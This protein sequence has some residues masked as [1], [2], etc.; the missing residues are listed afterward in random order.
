VRGGTARGRTE[1]LRA[2]P[3]RFR[4]AH[5]AGVSLRIASSPDLAALST[6]PFTYAEVGATR[7]PATMPAGYRHRERSAVVGSG[8]TAFERCAAAVLDW[9]C[10]RA[11]PLRLRAS[12]PA[13]DV[14]A[15]AVL[16][17]GLPALG[18]DIPCRVVWSATEGN[19]RGFAYGSL[20]G[21]P[22]SGE[23]AFLVRI[24][25]DGV[26]RFTTWVFS[27]LTS[28]LARLGGPVSWGVQALALRAYVGAARHA[29]G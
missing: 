26:V 22:E 25:D 27:R 17:A 23:E 6:A 21:H 8:R 28:P 14:G 20:P 3:I 9:G 12:G 18:Y 10:Q 15:V 4:R 29:A 5:S 2:E 24:D 11:L 19:E 7:D 1:T 16:T 13:S